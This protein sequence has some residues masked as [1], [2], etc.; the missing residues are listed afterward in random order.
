MDPEMTE[1]LP[2]GLLE[3]IE[4]FLAWLDLERGLSSHTMDGYSRDL[5]QCA[6]YLHQAGCS[7]WKKVSPALLS[8]FSAYLT[9]TGYARSSQ[10]RKISAVR[11]L[12]KH[13][14]REN[15]RPD[16]C[17]ALLKGPAQ[18]RKLP[19]VLT[20]T[21]VEAL[22][23]APSQHSSLGQRDRAILELFYSSGLRVSELCC[24]DLQ[25]VYLDEG[26][27]RILGKGNKE[28]IAPIG[29]TAIA[30]LRNYLST[31]RPDLVKN[32][33]GSAFFLSRRGGALSR[34]MIWVLIK[35]HAQTAGIKK[36]VK[37]HLLRHSF[38]THLLEGGADLRAI[39]EMLGHVD[40]ATTQIYT[41]LKAEQLSDAHALH[42]PRGR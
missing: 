30:S 35:N 27:L 14:V 21:E 15:L 11:S 9:Q 22:L 18:H 8:E 38:A 41:A 36:E 4:S 2:D 24:L 42:H 40:I 16:D 12:S 23:A 29:S 39:Q 5:K 7:C 3:P 20:R 6:V 34:K 33:T 17:A 37:P 32:N 25:N 28:R 19:Q 13:M 31:A 10:S 1:R 26:Y